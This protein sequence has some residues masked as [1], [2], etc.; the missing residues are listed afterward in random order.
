MQDAETLPNPV[1]RAREFRNG[2]LISFLAA[3]PVR[4]RNLAMIAVNR[5]L[6]LRGERYWLHFDTDET[7]GGD[8][9]DFP[10]PEAL[11]N[12]LVRYLQ[13]YRSVLVAKTISLE[14]GKTDAR[15]SS[16]EG[17]H[18]LWVVNRKRGLHKIITKRTAAWFGQPVNPHSFRHA[19]A[20]SIAIEDPAHVGIVVRIL[21]H[22]SLRTA[23]KYYNKATS[24]EAAR[25]YQKS[26]ADLRRSRSQR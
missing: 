11:H 22:S 14:R 19:A 23:E 9:L 18:H 21:G 8:D 17:H 24:I 15:N 25:R 13:V 4:A 16:S 6:Q 5:H 7:K 20:T 3:R 10:W 26:I 12:A 2:L 1:K